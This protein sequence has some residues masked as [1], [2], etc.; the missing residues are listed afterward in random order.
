MANTA[1]GSVIVC[2][3]ANQFLLPKG[4]TGATDGGGMVNIKA[5]SMDWSNGAARFALSI[6]DSLGA[7]VCFVITPS[8]PNLHFDGGIN[9]E[10]LMVQ[11]I[12]NGTGYIYLG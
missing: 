9:C 10:N 6:G 2:D 11:T 4:P 5:L 1:I 12:A 7:S 3:S 8:C